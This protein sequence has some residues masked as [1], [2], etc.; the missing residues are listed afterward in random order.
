MGQQCFEWLLTSPSS[1]E[2]DK[3][4]YVVYQDYKR[5]KIMQ[6]VNYKKSI[7]CPVC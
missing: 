5:I 4:L 7:I 1:A 6:E 2:N 3:G